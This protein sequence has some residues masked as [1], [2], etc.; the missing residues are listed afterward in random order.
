MLTIRS[1]LHSKLR[2]RLYP[3]VSQTRLL[4]S[5]ASD[6]HYA[7]M[8][9]NEIRRLIINLIRKGAIMDVDCTCNPRMCRVSVG[10]P[11]NES[12]ESLQTT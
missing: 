5:R 1:V 9:A 7:D 12:A 6:R 2:T 10:E 11:H 4:A 3:D 8:D